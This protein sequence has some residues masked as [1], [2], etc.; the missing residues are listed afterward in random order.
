MTM[1]DWAARIDKFLQSD[2]RSVLPNTGTV[3]AEQAKEYAES[4]FEKYRIIQDRMF[5]SDFDRL[6]D[7]LPD[8]NTDINKVS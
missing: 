7:N 1:E 4:E 6:S 2:D 5:R 3:S 8:F